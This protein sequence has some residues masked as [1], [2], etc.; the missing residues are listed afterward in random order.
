[1]HHV[2]ICEQKDFSI[3]NSLRQSEN[4]NFYIIS[5]TRK[6][7]NMSFEKFKSVGADAKYNY[8]WLTRIAA[9]FNLAYTECMLCKQV[10]FVKEIN[11]IEYNFIFIEKNKNM[12]FITENILY[13]L[14][15]SV[16]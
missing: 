8:L 10:D 1:M 16:W 6:T 12:T 5:I 7:L 11:Y 4:T 3:T 15:F 14:H 2:I 9:K 13:I